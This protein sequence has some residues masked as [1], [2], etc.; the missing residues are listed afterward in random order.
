MLLRDNVQTVDSSVP[1]Q[2]DFNK[3]QPANA[4]W[5][6]FVTFGNDIVSMLEQYLNAADSI[7]VTSG[8]N[9]VIKL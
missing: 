4:L 7:V 6:I 9:V 8:N 2:I 3:R 1:T 5:P